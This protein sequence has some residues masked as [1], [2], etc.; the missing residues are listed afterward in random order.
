MVETIWTLVYL[1]SAHAV[2]TWYFDN[3]IPANRGVVQPWNFFLLP[4]YWLPGLFGENSSE[5]EKDAV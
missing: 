3:T 4:S 1:I 2:L 5:K